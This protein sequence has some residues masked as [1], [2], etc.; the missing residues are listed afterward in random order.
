MPLRL[1]SKE[2]ARAIQ[3]GIRING[4]VQSNSLINTNQKEL[5]LQQLLIQK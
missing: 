5:L 1:D 3:E 4:D 2:T